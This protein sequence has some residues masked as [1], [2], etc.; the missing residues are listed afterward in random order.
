MR[1]PIIAGNWKMNKTKNEALDFIQA[2]KGAVPSQEKVESV[3]CS[4]HL[5]LDALVQESVGSDVKIGAQ[6]MHFEENGAFTGEVSPAALSDLG[7]QYVVIGHSERREMFG[8]TD[9][10]V[11]QKV[12]AAFKFGLT[13]IVCVGESLEQRES[14]QTNDVVTKQ[15]NGGLKGLSEDQVKQTVIAYEPIWAIGTGKTATSKDANETCGVV[16][17][18]V[19]DAFSADAAEAVRIQYG[20]SV[21]P[22][23][24]KELLEQSDID[25]A[26]VG[27]ASLEAEAF[28]QLAEAGNE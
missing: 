22:A 21:K 9:E 18:A 14:D 26:L 23:N 24:I 13:P 3:V 2:V 6:N 8:E 27:G 15:V 28:L 19:K 12:H 4:P 1:K 11:N 10:S 25:G 7:V 17:A 5:F 16:R 20:G